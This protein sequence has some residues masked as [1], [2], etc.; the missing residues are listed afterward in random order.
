MLL[1]I[2]RDQVLQDLLAQECT[3]GTKTITIDDHG[4]KSF[5]VQGDNGETF[6]VKGSYY[7]AN[8]LQ[9]IWLGNGELNTDNVQMKPLQRIDYL[10]NTHY[11][12]VL[13]R[14][15]NAE[16]VFANLFDEK[17][18][19]EQSY[20][21]VP[22]ADTAGL[23][24]YRRITA[25]Y[26]NITVIE[27]PAPPYSAELLAKID[28]QP[29]LLALKYDPETDQ[30]LPYVVPG[31]RF[32]E[33]YGW[34]SYFI[35]LGLMA[36][37]QYEL[38]RGMLEN[39]AY[40]IKYYGKMLNANRSYYLTRSQ[41]PFYTPYL[42]AFYRQYADRL[43]ENWLAEHLAIAI[44]EYQQVWQNP[45]THYFADIGLNHYFDKGI[46][47]PKETETGHFRLILQQFADKHGMSWQDFERE[48]D[49][50]SLKEPELDRYFEHDRAMRESGHDTTTRLDDVC[51]DTACVDL[52]AILYR[53]EADIAQL[54]LEYY[55]QGFEYA[56]KSYQ[57]DDFFEYAET[58]YAAMQKYLWNEQDGTFYDYNHRTQQ[59]NHFVSA[60]NLFPLW[61]KACNPIQAKRTVA[62]QLPQLLREGGIASTAP[63][64]GSHGMER[65]WD[66]PYGWAP[67][68][69]IVW[70]GLANFGFEQEMHQA[71]YAWVRTIVRATVEYNGLIPEKFN[72]EHSSHKTDVEYGNVGA[73]FD[74]VPAGGFGWTNAS[75][76]LGI[77]KLTDEQRDE[78]N[79][80]A[81]STP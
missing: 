19:S 22:A 8:L 2:N 38:A 3:Q 20:L 18:S 59:Q 54:L 48:Y 11:W 33:M 25:P 73:V 36:H 5:T 79:A 12:N 6:E 16:N 57:Y 50:G 70:E 21:Y 26:S 9:E 37:D 47:R 66:Y 75:L 41:P 43:P 60:T 39:I 17:R 24:Y 65:Q 27:L 40:Q 23:A 67:H 51:A 78:L 71:A 56:G 46:G 76:I 58:R 77:A 14:R 49:A 13:S 80:L 10:M 64:S 31:G 44:Q 15:M 72:V 53:V 34:D 63:I 30:P 55:P 29:G 35:G 61:A 45:N 7:L 74:Y 42:A 68:Q 81:D 32:N 28:E 62:S 4:K 52:N 69:I 1:K